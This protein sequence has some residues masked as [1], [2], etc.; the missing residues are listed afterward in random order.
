MHQSSNTQLSL[1]PPPCDE[2]TTSDPFFSATRV[3]PPGVMS[4]PLGET[5]TKG[6]RSTWRGARPALVK[7]GTVDSASVGWAI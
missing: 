7:I 6:R 3:S 1:V 4:T 5:S 2:L